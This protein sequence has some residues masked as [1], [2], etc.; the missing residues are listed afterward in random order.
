MNTDCALEGEQEPQR[1]KGR[2]VRTDTPKRITL[3][4]ALDVKKKAVD[5]ATARRCSISRLVEDLIHNC[6]TTTTP[7]K[8]TRP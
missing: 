5:L 6:E 3:H 7:E 8:T 2:P 4:L 1:A